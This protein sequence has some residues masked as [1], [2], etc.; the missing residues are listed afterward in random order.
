M[1][2]RKNTPR[3]A[4]KRCGETSLGRRLAPLRS[5][6]ALGLGAVALV[7]AT[8]TAFAQATG[9]NDSLR[10]TPA[11]LALDDPDP[12]YLEFGAGAYDLIGDHGQ[13]QTF[14]AS[15]EYHLA[16]KLFFIGPAV[17]VI[18]NARGG[19]MVYAG[20]YSD[21]AVGPIVITPLAG[22]GAWWH[23]N[24][25]DENLGGTFEFRLSL[26]AAYEFADS[27]HLGLRF[28]HI[29]SA[30]I[31]KRNPGENDLMLTYGLPLQL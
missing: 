23:G 14:A 26:E 13:H 5:I 10:L 9:D 21:I 25:V 12:S 31:N 29:S 7:G 27:S 17:G 24:H 19:G 2:L 6:L 28:G 1:R 15:A 30:G 22:L 18:A 8:A 11:K 4:R 20:L 16:E 3:H